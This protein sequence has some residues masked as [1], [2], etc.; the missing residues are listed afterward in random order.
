MCFKG[1]K[2]GVIQLG[3]GRLS[4]LDGP[5]CSKE[6]VGNASDDEGRKRGLK[7]RYAAGVGEGEGGI[8]LFLVQG[9]R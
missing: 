9:K 6:E 4:E 8:E 2:A 3:M 5:K 1:H 7:P